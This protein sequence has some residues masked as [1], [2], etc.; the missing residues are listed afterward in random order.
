MNFDRNFRRAKT[1]IG[2]GF[3][4]R[5]L[6]S[7]AFIVAIVLGSIYVVREINERGLKD[8]IEEVWEGPEDE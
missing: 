1:A 7:V 3:V 8:I 5:M 2:I 4:I 6:L